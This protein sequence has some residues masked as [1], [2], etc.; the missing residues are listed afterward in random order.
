MQD[1]IEKLDQTDLMN[2]DSSL[3][4]HLNVHFVNVF[5]HTPWSLPRCYGHVNGSDRRGVADERHR[6]GEVAKSGRASD[7]RGKLWRKI[8]RCLRRFSMEGVFVQC[9]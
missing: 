6:G 4:Q 3:M 1:K 8:W 5:S 9:I 2:M 7:R